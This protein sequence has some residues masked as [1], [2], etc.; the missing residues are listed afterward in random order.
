MEKNNN[1]LIAPTKE[2]LV[3]YDGLLEYFKS[4]HS[5][6]I[7][8]SG[9]VDSTFLLYAAHEALGRNVIAITAESIVFP[10][11]ELDEADEYCKSLRVPHF[12][13]EIDELSI[14]GFSKNPSDRCYIC[15]KHIF[16]KLFE[17]AKLNG[18][19]HVAEGSNLDDTGDYRPGLIAIAELG[20]KSPLREIGFTKLEI[21]TML[22]Y[23]GIKTATKPSFACLATRFPYGET[24]TKEKLAMVDNAEQYL[25]NMG[26]KQFRVRIHD[27]VARIE[28]NPDDFP[29]IMQENNRR[30]I[31]ETFKSYGFSY[32]ALDLIGYR[33]GSMNEVLFNNN[34]KL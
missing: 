20:V 34:Q 11:R 30:N 5:V 15:K 21:R 18:I 31:Y 27:D 8:F 12:K 4:L 33:T 29:K 7:A 22:N 16:E 17:L 6:A 26:F 24:I 25:F 32:V 13:A 19:N 1:E 9:G 10:K 23:F 28:L 2:L 14:D 3:K